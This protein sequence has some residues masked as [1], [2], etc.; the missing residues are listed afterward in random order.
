M[1]PFDVQGFI[2]A[3]NAAGLCCPDGWRNS[4]T[5]STRINFTPGECDLRADYVSKDKAALEKKLPAPWRRLKEAQPTLRP[6]LQRHGF[7]ELLWWD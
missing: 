5:P 7:K 6:F 4:L 1:E 2:D 3:C